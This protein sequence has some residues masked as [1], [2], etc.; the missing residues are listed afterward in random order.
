MEPRPVRNTGGLYSNINNLTNFQGTLY[1]AG[2][3]AVE[4]RAGVELWRSD[5]TVGGTFMVKDIDPT[6]Y[7]KHRDRLQQMASSNPQSFEI[8]SAQ[9]VF[10]NLE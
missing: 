2:G 7:Y 4:G 5:G 3:A 6:T 8:F 1:F 10:R 9:L